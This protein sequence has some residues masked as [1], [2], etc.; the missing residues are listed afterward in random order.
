MNYMQN[1]SNHKNYI[2]KNANQQVYVNTKRKIMTCYSL[3]T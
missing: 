2:Q 1:A 3:F